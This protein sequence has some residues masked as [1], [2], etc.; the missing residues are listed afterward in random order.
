MAIML[1]CLN[2]KE[3]RD[4][5]KVSHLL[6]DLLSFGVDVIAIQETYFVSDVD[7]SVLSCDFIVYSTYRDR[8][9]RGVAGEE[10][11]GCEGR[12]CPCSVGR[13]RHCREKWLL[14]GCC[15]LCT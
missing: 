12:P 5:I 15:G 10:V 7:T 3:L 6:Y 14:S 2:V 9:A 13:G 11:T 1:A 8:L 4:R